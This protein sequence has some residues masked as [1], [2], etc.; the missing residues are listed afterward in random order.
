MDGR[1]REDLK[2]SGEQFVKASAAECEG[3]PLA[4]LFVRLVR[5][6]Y[7]ETERWAVEEEGKVRTLK[8]AGSQAQTR[9]LHLIS[10]LSLS[11]FVGP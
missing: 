4:R 5:P 10:L 1:R 8:M 6:N 2:L 7:Q 3:G 9:P 11:V